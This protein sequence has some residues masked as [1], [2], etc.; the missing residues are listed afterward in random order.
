[1]RMRFG[2]LDAYRGIAALAV[3]VF[4]L[5]GVKL[6][7]NLLPHA[8]L[9]V[10]FFFILS[11]FVI[12]YTYEAKL[13]A[14]MTVGDF[15]GRRFIR[16]YP[17]VFLAVSLG[18]VVLL[19]KVYAAPDRVDPLGKVLGSIAS[20]LAILPNLFGGPASRGDLFPGNGPLWSIFLEIVVNV[21]WC[22]ALV[23]TGTRVLSVF[24]AL[25][26]LA[27]MAFTLTSGSANLGF[28]WQTLP[29]G[30]A[31]IGYGF[32]LGHLMYRAKGLIVVK[33][34]TLAKAAGAC[35]LAIVFCGPRIVGLDA[36]WDMVCIG[37]V[38]P[39]IVIL[40]LNS[41]DHRRLD[42]LFGE[43]SYPL[44]ATH[45]PIL[46]LASGLHQSRP[47][48][49]LA[50]LL[51]ATAILIAATTAA[52]LKLYDEPVRL[53]LGEKLRAHRGTRGLL[54]VADGRPSARGL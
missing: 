44:Y 22:T 15:L 7:P 30:L 40:G 21:V 20:N 31:R 46:L 14:G 45:F 1:M 9:A 6:G 5:R 52:A 35:L 18:A 54:S 29:A 49:A 37:L 47:Q 36:V 17:M 19:M 10:D 8:Y 23:R 27:L 13:A 50:P 16:L 28:D 12:A 2:A 43:V 33:Q 39:L 24:V 25:C 48:L 38:M 34:R 41:T 3:V 53:W 51:A 26:F 32:G 11:G 4:H 42:R